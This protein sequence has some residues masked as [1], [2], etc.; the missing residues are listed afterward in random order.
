VHANE[1]DFDQRLKI[2][3]SLGPALSRLRKG[4]LTPRES[5]PFEKSIWEMSDL[6][7]S[8]KGDKVYFTSTLAGVG[9]PP[10]LTW[11]V[12]VASEKLRLFSSGSLRPIR[13][14]PHAGKLLRVWATY[15]SPSSPTYRPGVISKCEIASEEGTTL[16]SLTDADCQK[17]LA[18][19]D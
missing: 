3:M 11:Q 6:A 9:A 10:Q 5:S 19:P 4:A 18:T 7:F 12:D 13:S 1:V 17:A 8:P 2:T 15:D 16:Q 14:G